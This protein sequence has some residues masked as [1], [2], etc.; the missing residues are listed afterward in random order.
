MKLVS[1]ALV[2]SRQLS[3]LGFQI[4]TPLLIEQP[5]TA[6]MDLLSTHPL[7][8]KATTAA[9]LGASGDAFV[10]LTEQKRLRGLTPSTYDSDVSPP[11]LDLAR[12]SSFAL[13]GACYTGAFQH[14]LFPFLEE[15]CQGF[16]LGAAASSAG[17]ELDPG[18]AAALE[19]TFSNQLVCIP[20]LYY[21]IFFAM[22]GALSG[23]DL[24]A[25]AERGRTLF[26]P[27]MRRNLAFWI[28]M[29]TIQFACIP[30][31]LQI[32]F[33]CAAGLGW[34]VILSA[35]SYSSAPAASAAPAEVL[36]EEADAEATVEAS[37][38]ESFDS[39]RIVPA[40]DAQ[41]KEPAGSMLP[42]KSD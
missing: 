9:V 33:V 24:Q 17:L 38:S 6:Y 15:Q 31:D 26:A 2:L 37:A 12:T 7:V 18:L 3:V 25:S 10:Q 30:S 28:P 35:A 42:P 4:P 8:T 5:A 22:T 23:L 13:F 1:L 14:Q 29:Q 11:A 41:V 27:L 16:V 21:P 36:A 19:R 40:V 20:L 32:P 34:N 39:G